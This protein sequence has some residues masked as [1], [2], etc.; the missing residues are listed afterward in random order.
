MPEPVN[1]FSKEKL[2]PRRNAVNSEDNSS[3]KLFNSQSK[4]P[5]TNFL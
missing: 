5:F 4:S 2:Q 1:A 3:V